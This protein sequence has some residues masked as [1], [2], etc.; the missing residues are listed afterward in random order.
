MDEC[1]IALAVTILIYRNVKMEVV[2]N[3]LVV[4]FDNT[5]TYVLDLASV[6][7]GDELVEDKSLA[8]LQDCI[9]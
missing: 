6:Q 1:N 9:R 8:M 4:S 2:N 7:A 3:E 5:L